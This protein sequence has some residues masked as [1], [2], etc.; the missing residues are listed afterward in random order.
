MGTAPTLRY[1]VATDKIWFPFENSTRLEYPFAFGNINGVYGVTWSARFP[2]A[3]L[4]AA[5]FKGMYPD[6]TAMPD[7]IKILD[8]A[9]NMDLA[10]NEREVT[11][12]LEHLYRTEPYEHQRDAIECMMHY[13]RLALL[14]EQG[15]GK[16]FISIM[17]TVFFRELGIPYKALIVCPN[18]VFSGWIE[19]IEKYS[20]LRV[21]PYK[22]SPKVRATQREAI[23]AAQWDCVLTTFDMLTDRAGSNSYVLNPSGQGWERRHKARMRSV[24]WKRQ[25]SRKN[26]MPSWHSPRKRRNGV[27][28]VCAF[29]G[30]FLRHSCP[31]PTCWMPESTTAAWSFSSLCPMTT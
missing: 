11:T 29:C 15:L 21:L 12:P 16:T 26:S 24:G 19:E 2:M 31:S 3:R 8:K 25:S 7:V 28:T 5:V 17:A 9:K 20:N 10:I 13:P 30:L 22:G 27:M 6:G 18:I 14:L 4:G 23:S 1:D